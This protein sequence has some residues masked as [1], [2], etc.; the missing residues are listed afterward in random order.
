MIHRHITFS[1]QRFCSSG[2]SS[3]LISTIKWRANKLRVS[4]CYEERQQRL[5]LDKNTLELKSRMIQ[6]PCIQ[7]VFMTFT[8]LHSLYSRL[9]TNNVA[10]RWLCFSNKSQQMD[11]CDI[12][13]TECESASLKMKLGHHW[14]IV[15]GAVN[16]ITWIW[17]RLL[18]DIN[19]NDYSSVN[20]KR[21][22]RQLNGSLSII[23]WGEKIWAK[24]LQLC[25][26]LSSDDLCFKLA[27]NSAGE[28]HSSTV[29]C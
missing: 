29:T 7:K 23:T 20:A 5:G 24:W 9:Q 19:K 26:F 8:S 10:A 1:Q 28:I 4:S 14:I 11:S 6:F 16:N 18:S 12:L 13:Q 21:K 3:S 22:S 25:Q 2:Q 17:L 27:W 15:T